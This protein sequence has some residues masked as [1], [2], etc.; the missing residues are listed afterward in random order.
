MC[1]LTH[2]NFIINIISFGLFGVQVQ[3]GQV[4]MANVHFSYIVVLLLGAICKCIKDS[5]N[6]QNTAEPQSYGSM[7]WL[8]FCGL[9]SVAFPSHIL[10]G[11]SMSRNSQLV[12]QQALNLD[13]DVVQAVVRKTCIYSYTGTTKEKIMSYVSSILLVLQVIHKN[14]IMVWE[15]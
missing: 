13:H 8:L 5:M 9:A 14:H 6:T 2:H 3:Q 15:G 12:S 7:N 4:P 1:L 11:I 10:T